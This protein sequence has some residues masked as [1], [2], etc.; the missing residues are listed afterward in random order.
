MI[1]CRY[2]G[3]MR[4]LWTWWEVIET[5]ERRMFAKTIID[6]DSFLDMPL[7]AQ[8]LYFHLSMRADDDG[9]VNSPKR[10]QRMIGASEDDLK[11]L[12]AKSFILA[13]DTGVIVIKH[14][15]INNWIRADRKISTTYTDEL[16]MLHIK[17]NGAYS[18]ETLEN[19]EVQPSDNQVTTKC[20]PSDNQ[21]SSQYRLDKDSKD[22]DSKDIVEQA[23]PPIEDDIDSIIDYLNAATSSSFSKSTDATRKAIRARLKAG[24]TVDDFRKVIDH[25]AEKWG[26]DERMSEYLRPQTLFSPSHFESYLNE[27]NR[28]KVSNAGTKGNKFTE[29]EQRTD[30]DFDELEKKLIQN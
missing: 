29:Y 8:S 9:F 28:P 12:L 13:F 19:R 20:Q 30:Y 5:A 3:N 2:I 26:H 25:K 18:F 22:K 17:N 10:I 6:S 27:A 4:H 24:A 14:W 7:S 11:L 15:R 21:M 1:G 16:E 23:R